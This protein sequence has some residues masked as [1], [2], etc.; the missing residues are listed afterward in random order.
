M[1]K[2]IKSL[3]V[4]SQFA[5]LILCAVI[6]CFLLF[7]ELWMNKWPIGTLI[8]GRDF[9]HTQLND[10]DFLDEFYKAAADYDLPESEEDAEAA[11][12]LDPL[13]SMADE[14]TSIYIYGREDGMYRAGRF[15]PIMDDKDFRIFFDW[16][17]RL[18]NGDG[19]D[20]SVFPLKFRNDTALVMM[21]NYQRSLFIYPYL[22]G[23]LFLSILLFFSIVLFFLA[24]K[25]RSVLAL[26]KE[27]LIMA[28]GD[29]THPVP[30]FGEDE[31]GILAKELDGLR[32]SLN[33]TILKEQESRLANQ[34]LITALSHDL[35]TPLTILTGYLEVLRLKR[36]PR[37]QEEYL[38]RCL[39]KTEDLKELTDKM[40]EYA[41]VLEENETPEITWTSTEF[42]RQCLMDNC[43]FIKLAGFTPGIH[44]PDTAS[45]LESDVT[46]LKRIFSNLFSNI[47]KYGDKKYP[48]TV[49]GETR[50]QHFAISVTNTAKS[51][52]TQITGSNIGLKSVQKMMRLLGGTMNVNK[53]AGC[54][55][56]TL[57]FPLNQLGTGHF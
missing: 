49:T 1:I 40:F 43:D 16:G 27:I 8:T 13:L 52:H 37:M 10:A 19:E 54:F 20:L 39:K 17:Y 57:L 24:R 35:R 11:L 41:L 5:L 50:K 36:S 22:A 28:S 30:D 42:I 55:T 25:M 9:S 3:K 12:A 15:A 45:T 23:S 48:V 4:S 44:F 31:I 56:V 29:L 51:E 6:L 26:E 18:T 53:N 21:Y 7:L 34:D 2:K 47:L 38:E 46:M 32:N 14:Y 33:E